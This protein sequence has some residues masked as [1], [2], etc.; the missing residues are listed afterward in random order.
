M[1]IG[2][3]VTTIELN[4]LDTSGVLEAMAA[5]VQ[6]A[7]DSKLGPH[8]EAACR[9][10]APVS[11][12]RNFAPRSFQKVQLRPE[13]QFPGSLR[14]PDSEASKH[15]AF[16]Q[17]G[18]QVR[19]L[20]AVGGSTV[21]KDVT[22][23][24]QGTRAKGTLGVSPSLIKVSGNTL[25]G[26]Y[27]HQPGTLRRSIR[28]VGSERHGNKIIGTVRAHAPYAAAV[29]KGF[30]HKGGWSKKTGKVSRIEGKKYMEAGLVHIVDRLGD[31][32]TYSG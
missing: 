13:S 28:Y 15:A 25:V 26:A 12:E 9:D 3:K 29:E 17:R 18:E 8:L 27:Q 22:R 20:K 7:F 2:L 5:K 14:V 31:P 10:E 21:N 23:F 6:E 1:S 4:S 30:S 19:L 11:A 32:H 24:F 16:G